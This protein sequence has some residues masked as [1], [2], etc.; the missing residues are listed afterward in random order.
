M[1]VFGYENAITVL[2]VRVRM[3]AYVYSQLPVVDQ[4]LYKA[5]DWL[6]GNAVR[7][8]RGLFILVAVRNGLSLRG[9]GAES[10]RAVPSEYGDE[11]AG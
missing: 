2:S 8:Y 4:P 11:F 6:R 5:S 7:A 1:R 3:Q 10:G 9:C